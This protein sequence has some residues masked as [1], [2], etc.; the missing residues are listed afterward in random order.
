[1]G[2]VEINSQRNESGVKKTLTNHIHVM[3]SPWVLST[4][5]KTAEHKRYFNSAECLDC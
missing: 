2:S 3:K 1:M 4:V 5:R